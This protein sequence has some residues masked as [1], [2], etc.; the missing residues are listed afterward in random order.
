MNDILD[1]AKYSVLNND[2]ARLIRLFKDATDLRVSSQEWCEFVDSFEVSLKRKI[3]NC[4]NMCG[5]G[6][7]R[8]IKPNISSVASIYLAA[9]TRSD[10]MKS[11]SAANTGVF[12]SSDFF[13]KIGVLG[14]KN[15]IEI[16]QKYHWGYCDHYELSP[17]KK[18][19]GI[20]KTNDSIRN[21]MDCTV[22]HDYSSRV[23]YLGISDPSFANKIN[24]YVNHNA[25]QQVKC[26]YSFHNFGCVDEA[27]AGE[28]F[29]NN[30]RICADR[31]I[32]YIPLKDANEVFEIDLQLLNGNCNNRFWLESL[33]RTIAIV[34]FDMCYASDIN[35]GLTMAYKAYKD[36]V[37]KKYLDCMIEDM[38]F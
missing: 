10:F 24:T 1:K 25:P 33:A 29:F 34:L 26:L 12:G 19:K 20:F 4:V 22:F 27:T 18:F 3:V 35:E 15:K 30:E 7:S 36:C 32:E 2:E 37:A 6:A 9:L 11:G 16:L 28:V 13:R 21:L 17:W 31:G 38:T 8:I 23:L 5:S 14:Y